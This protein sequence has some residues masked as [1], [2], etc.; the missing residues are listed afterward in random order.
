MAF[1]W[2]W[3]W[4]SSDLDQYFDFETYIVTLTSSIIHKG[5][6]TGM[7]QNKYKHIKVWPW[8]WPYDLHSETLPKYNKYVLPYQQWSFYAMLFEDHSLY[9]QI[10]VQTWL[11][12]VPFT[13][14]FTK[15]TKEKKVV[16]EQK[17]KQIFFFM[18]MQGTC[19]STRTVTYVLIYKRT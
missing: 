17:F 15:N 13:Y 6:E 19:Y 2:K 8:L 16:R 3:P 5:H 10:D 11:K 9:R 1:T 4:P 18:K 12:T 7:L 14:A